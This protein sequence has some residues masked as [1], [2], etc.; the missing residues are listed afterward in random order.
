MK[1][2][3]ASRNFFAR[4]VTLILGQ[5]QLR[6]MLHFHDK[7][8]ETV[9]RHD[10]K[11]AARAVEDNFKETDVRIRLLLQNAAGADKVRKK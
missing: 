10:A 9:E 2:T 11:A 3:S 6:S 7:L 4:N 8:I 1:A 5:G